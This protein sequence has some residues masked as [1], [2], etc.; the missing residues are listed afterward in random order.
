MGKKKHPSTLILCAKSTKR[1]NGLYVFG[2]AVNRVTQKRKSET[3]VLVYDRV[4]LVFT[5]ETRSKSN[6]QHC[7]VE[8]KVM[9]GGGGT[10]QGNPPTRY[11]SSSG[12]LQ[13][14]FRD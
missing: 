7:P 12:S 3:R 14:L 11:V 1:D 2:P 13:D 4:R 5:A 10:C 9:A 6:W 8:L